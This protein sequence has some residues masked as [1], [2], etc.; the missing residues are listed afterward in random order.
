MS[1]SWFIA[2]AGQKL[3]PYPAAQLQQMAASGRVEPGDFLLAAGSSA[4]VTAGSQPW[5]FPVQVAAGTIRP[6]TP[7]SSPPTTPAFSPGYGGPR[8]PRPPEKDNSTV[9]LLSV[10]GGVFLLVLLLV[11]GVFYM[12]HLMAKRAGE[13]FAAVGSAL[14]DAQQKAEAERKK[15]AEMQEAELADEKLTDSVKLVKDQLKEQYK[16]LGETLL[17]VDRTEGKQVNSRSLRRKI[18]LIRFRHRPLD[19]DDGDIKEEV[20][21][22]DGTKIFTAKWPDGWEAMKAK[23]DLDEE[24]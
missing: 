24:P 23:Y 3:G 4:Y 6:G 5:L 14:V 15:L 21:L 20:F 9:V 17:V 2:R 7:T 13:S 1:D 11:G 10:L 8:Q 12:F 22:V 16:K 18:T 19:G